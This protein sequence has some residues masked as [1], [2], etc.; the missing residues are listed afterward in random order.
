MAGGKIWP[1]KFCL[2]KVNRVH[3][4]RFL[5]A[6][7]ANFGTRA[8]DRH[9]TSDQNLGLESIIV[10]SLGKKKYS[11]R[12]QDAENGPVVG[13]KSDLALF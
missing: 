13:F 10:T 12:P 8:A 2:K 11:L 5:I 7:F 6:V 3:S 1:E 4:F 9:N